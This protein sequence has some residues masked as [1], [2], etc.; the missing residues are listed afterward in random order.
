MT[1]FVS[2]HHKK[3]ISQLILYYGMAMLHYQQVNSRNN[4]IHFWG[5]NLHLGS[6]IHPAGRRALMGGWV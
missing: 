6:E 1:T 2:F 3:S 4:I 5:L